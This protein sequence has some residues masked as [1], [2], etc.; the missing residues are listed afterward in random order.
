[1]ATPNQLSTPL[2]AR[3]HARR[4]SGTII[5]AMPTIPAS[6]ARDL[7]AGIKSQ[8]VVWDETIAAGEYCGRILKRG[9][10]LRI[11]NLE[12]DGCVN[13]LLYN[14]D[15]NQERL[16]VADTVKV[17]WNA[18]LGKGNLLLS[19][20]G[21]VLMSLVEDTCGKHDAFCGA[22]NEKSNAAKYGQGDNYSAYPNAHD[23]FLLTLLKYGLGKKDIPANINLFK[24]ARIEED[25]GLTF[26]EN[27]SKPGD[28]VELRAEMNV[29]VAVANTPHVLDPRAEYI[30]TPVRLIAYHGPAAA[31]DDPIRNASPE[32]L[33]AFQNTEDF[34]LN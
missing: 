20:M 1:M 11:I 33:R 13:L 32:S 17:Q 14:A 30:C 3:D 21:R 16:N 26:V 18:Y 6:A 25:G 29:L 2:K 7:P 24:H 4:Q 23:R 8:D 27:A 31:A 19:D 5:R 34:F 12:G 22:S 15:R 10:R 9:T 28:F